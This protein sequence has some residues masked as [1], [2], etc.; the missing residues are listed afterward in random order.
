MAETRRLR[1][2]GDTGNIPEVM[3]W[4]ESFCEA[5]PPASAFEYKLQLVAEELL[6]NTIMHGYGEKRENAS[7]WLTLHPQPEGAAL[8]LED[9]GPPFDP[10]EEGPRPDTDAAIED[11]PIGGL[12][13]MLVREMTDRASYSRDAYNRLCLVFGPGPLPEEMSPEDT[14]R[15]KRSGKRT[16]IR[17]RGLTLR[18]LAILLFL[19]VAGLMA[20]GALNYL[21]FERIL[22][23]AAAARYDPVLREL[24]RAIGDSLGEGLTLAS[25]RTTE[26]L[27]ERSVTQFDGAFDLVVHDSDG[28]RLF[29]TLEG[30]G[31]GFAGLPAPDEIHHDTDAPDRFTGRMSIMHDARPVGVLSLYHDATEARK[32]MPDLT[33]QIGRA[34]VVAVLPVL[35]VLILVTLVV[36]G[37]IEG[38]THDRRLAIDLA[39]RPDSPDPGTSDPLV[40]AIWRLSWPSAGQGRST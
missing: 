22:T 10:L 35:P 36:L 12:G 19:P 1:I 37:R 17:P 9:E 33:R 7:I 29:G 6:M 31:D 13:V 8:V 26:N 18:I 38:R 20:A 25:T 28:T 11:R 2:G 23:E 21:K 4:I 24:V 40:Q 34:G 32:A 15:R 5:H 30:G 3:S 27:I 39:A 14:R 16:P